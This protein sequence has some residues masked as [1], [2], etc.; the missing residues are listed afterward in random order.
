M[1]I[2]YNYNKKIETLFADQ[3]FITGFTR[4]GTS[5]ISFLIGSLDR[6]HL[7]FEPMMINLL[8]NSYDFKNKVLLKGI[9]KSYFFEDFYISYKNGRNFNFNINDESNIKKYKDIK[10]IRENLSKSKRRFEII[11]NLNKNEKIAIKCANIFFKQKLLNEYSIKN[12]IIMIRKPDDILKSVVQKGW[13]NKNYSHKGFTKSFKKVN[14]KGVP[15]HLDKKEISIWSS[16]NN[17][18]KF[19]WEIKKFNESV[20]K[21]NKKNITIIDYN[22][23]C[24]NPE[25]YLNFL[26]K[27]HNLQSTKITSKIIK[28]IKPL[29]KN[30]FNYKKF[31]N[32]LNSKLYLDTL[33]SYEEVFKKRLT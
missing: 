15:F 24:N 25:Y 14:N 32:N 31:K 18:E 29:K 28:T 33:K 5:I 1:N 17:S 12:L 26:K 19:C 3:I 11:N 2:K 9:Y 22:D 20:L 21:L 27:K 7:S 16:M 13:V 30:H 23:F 8:L 4:S 10:F 6:V